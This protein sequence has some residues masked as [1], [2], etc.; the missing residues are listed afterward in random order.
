LIDKPF[1]EEFFKSIKK[2]EVSTAVG[3]NNVFNFHTFKKR[4][5]PWQDCIYFD[6]KLIDEE[7]HRYLTGQF[8]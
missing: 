6:L 4:I 5:L 1:L 8:N 2:E 7:A 3:T